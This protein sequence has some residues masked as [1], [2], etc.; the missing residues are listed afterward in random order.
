V[1]TEPAITVRNELDQF[2][3]RLE[4]FFEEMRLANYQVGPRITPAA[5]NDVKGRLIN[6][7]N[8][9][10][11]RSIS[12][13]TMENLTSE[14]HKAQVNGLMFGEPSEAGRALAN[15]AGMVNQLFLAYYENRVDLRENL[16]DFLGPYVDFWALIRFTAGSPSRYSRTATP[17]HKPPHHTFMELKFIFRL[18]SYRPRRA[19]QSNGELADF[20]VVTRVLAYKRDAIREKGQKFSVERRESSCILDN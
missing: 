17:H 6:N 7:T 5:F 2:Y 11:G 18:P 16:Q 10:N 14:M 9:V 4:A 20:A 12:L 8:Q 1:T 15:H 13:T 19:C 3:D